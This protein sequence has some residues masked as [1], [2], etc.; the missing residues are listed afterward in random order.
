[1]SCFPPDPGFRNFHGL[2]NPFYN[3]T[4]A[5]HFDFSPT[6]DGTTFHANRE[7]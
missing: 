5:P 6:L 2:E 1:M 7:S 4:F 3:G